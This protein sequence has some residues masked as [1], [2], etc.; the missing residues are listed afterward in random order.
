MMAQRNQTTTEFVQISKRGSRVP[1]VW[2]THEMQNAVEV[3]L[4]GI[5]VTQPLNSLVMAEGICHQ[6]GRS[7]DVSCTAAANSVIFGGPDKQSDQTIEVPQECCECPS[8]MRAKAAAKFL[9]GT[10]VLKSEACLTTEH[11]YQ[12]KLQCTCCHGVRPNAYIIQCYG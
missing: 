3:H 6:V 8:A 7:H 12:W 1:S 4:K 11:E 9:G 5:R 10:H 2:Q